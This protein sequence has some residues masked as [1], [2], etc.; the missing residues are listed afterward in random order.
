MD[1][2]LTRRLAEV[3]RIAVR[4]ESDTGVPARLLI[5]QWAVESKWGAKP[6]GD[7][8]YFGIKK[9]V[10]HTKFCTMMTREV[11]AGQEWRLRLEFADYDSLEDSCCDYAWLIS[12]GD[13]YR[14]A[15][16]H[17]QQTGDF[18]ALV[19][20]MAKTYATDPGY[21]ALLKEIAAQANVG[22]AIHAVQEVTVRA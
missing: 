1:E 16:D 12:H 21:G 5:G 22:T 13:P 19:D 14:A 6:V 9:A 17:Y 2:N 10:R 18:C 3:A 20:S 11:I 7:A 8:N 15:W 4:L